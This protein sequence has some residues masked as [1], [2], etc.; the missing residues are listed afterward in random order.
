MPGRTVPSE[1]DS[2][3]RLGSCRMREA[4]RRLGSVLSLFGNKIKIGFRPVTR[5][6]CW[7]ESRLSSAL[8]GVRLV[9]PFRIGY[10]LVAPRIRHAGRG[11]MMPDAT[12]RVG[13]ARDPRHT[14]IISM[15]HPVRH[16]R[17]PSDSESDLT[18]SKAGECDQSWTG[19]W[20]WLVTPLVFECISRL[21][22]A[23]HKGLIFSKFCLNITFCHGN[24]F[25][26]N[27]CIM[28]VITDAIRPEMTGGT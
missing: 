3:R 15:L 16:P 20:G 22:L 19:D 1:A 28:T 13:L 12:I 27:R 23:K 10:L 5:P 6:V 25:G 2:D 21:Q 8:V 11:A 14:C 7:L 17:P 9:S 24:K 18:L 4:R 26:R